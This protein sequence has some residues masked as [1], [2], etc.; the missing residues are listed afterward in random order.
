VGGV[1]KKIGTATV[2]EEEKRPHEPA[3]QGHEQENVWGL[4]REKRAKATKKPPKQLWVFVLEKGGFHTGGGA[5]WVEGGAVS[6]PRGRKSGG[7]VLVGWGASCA[8]DGRGAGRTERKRDAKKKKRLLPCWGG[9]GVGSKEDTGDVQQKHK[10]TREG[11]GWWSV[12][13]GGGS[14]KRGQGRP[15]TARRHPGTQPTVRGLKTRWV[16]VFVWGRRT[17]SE[18]ASRGTHGESQ[19]NQAQTP[20]HGAE[21]GQ[22][23]WRALLGQ[24]RA[25]TAARHR[26]AP[27]G[28]HA[29]SPA[30]EGPD[31]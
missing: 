2:G 24:A 19:R 12:G 5:G 11:G 23:G 8:K 9:R 17:H 27:P 14:R 3:Q 29:P 10:K 4:T 31:R 7:W 6:S 1:G 21:P 15:G 26:A 22:W 20:P 28:A 16:G 13:G 18:N 25:T 30:A